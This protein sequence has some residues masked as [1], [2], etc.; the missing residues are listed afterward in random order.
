MLSMLLILTATTALVAGD[1]KTPEPKILARAYWPY[2]KAN[3]DAGKKG[4]TVVI[5]S[6]A[7]LIKRSPWSELDA[8]PQ[9]VEKNATEA[10]AKLLKEPDID[11]KK[12]MLIVVT[13]GAK[14]T[15]GWKVNVDA[16]KVQE[17][18]L[19]VEWSVTPPKGFAT[20]AF[21]H[22]GQVILVE[23]WDGPVMFATGGKKADET[24]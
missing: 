6:A 21:T 8:P 4:E 5:R 19:T 12:Q 13:A 15:G 14:P 22:P 10:V 7:E 16:L 11:W 20:Q 23:R 24:K 3:P 1:D 18:T 17:K 2:G 9:V